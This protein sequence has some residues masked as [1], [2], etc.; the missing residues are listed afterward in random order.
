VLLKDG[1]VYADVDILLDINLD[2]FITPSMSFFVPRDIVGDYANENFCLWNGLIGASPGHPFMARA[3]E[4]LLTNVLN[5]FDYYDME[6]DMCH[7]L[8]STGEV[9]KLRALTIL[10]LS[11]PCLLGQAVNKA[12]GRSGY[13][14]KYDTGWMTPTRNESGIGIQNDVG[15]ALLLIASRADMGALRFSDVDRN[16][17]VASTGMTELSKDPILAFEDQLKQASEV[18]ASHLHYSSF[19]HANDVFGADSIYVDN[20]VTNEWIRVKISH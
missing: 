1:G 20:L 18:E 4:A 6:R 14:S 8:G 3:V 17:I 19:E 15:D 12:L 5:R 9:W 16:M 11:G 10:S 2:S 7:D 13:L